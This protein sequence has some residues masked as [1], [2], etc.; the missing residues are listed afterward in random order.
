M[1]N[2]L[3]DRMHEIIKNHLICFHDVPATLAEQYAEL[4]ICQHIT[5]I[6]NNINGYTLSNDLYQE[7]IDWKTPEYMI[8]QIDEI[9]KKDVDF[10]NLIVMKKQI[11]ERMSIF[12]QEQKTFKNI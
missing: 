7:T 12:E 10:P 6:I 5:K 3:L 8:E 4:L 1:K 9:L 11:K 2:P